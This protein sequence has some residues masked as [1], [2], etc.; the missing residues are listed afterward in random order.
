MKKLK[1]SPV[2]LVLASFAG[3]ILAGALLLM[4]PF[5]SRSHNFTD[6]VTALFTATSATCVTGLVVVDT[7]NYWSFFGQ[8]VILLLIQV[9]GLGYMTI[10]TFVLL[11]LRKRISLRERIVLKEGLNIPHLRKIIT[12][13]RVVL[14]T[15]LLMEGTG[16][17]ILF[18]RFIKIFPLYRAIWASVFHSVSAFCNAGFDVIGDF[19]SFT[20]FVNDLTINLVIMTLIVVGG[21]GFLVVREVVEYVLDRQRGYYTKKL[22]LHTRIVLK[23]T[24][25]LILT[26]AMLIFILE[27]KMPHTLAPLPLRGKILASFFQSVTPRTAGFN[28]VD[29][30]S[31]TQPTLIVLIILMFIGGSPGGTAGGIKTT[32]FVVVLFLLLNAYKENEPIVV[33]GRTIPLKTIRKAVF[34]SGFALI[35]IFTSTFLILINEGHNFTFLQVLFEVT[36]AF[37][38]VG[39]STGITPH[40]S[41]F[42]RIVIIL[43]MFIGRVGPL[44]FIISLSTRRTVYHPRYPEEDVAVG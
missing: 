24:L 25:I 16:A 6:P 12:F 1:L 32:T 44:S 17:F 19:K 36:S 28:T 8:L 31:L 26:G 18:L 13:A 34:I 10:A 5:A 11:G 38:T 23:T 41:N 40:L 20:P 30:G 4:L 22:S 7:Y 15:T 42:S 35:L 3:V 2:Q 39:L 9:G 43:T 14:Y 21:I 33:Q 27:Y 37:G 29:I